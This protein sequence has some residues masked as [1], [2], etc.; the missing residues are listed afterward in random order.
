MKGFFERMKTECFY[1]H[2][3]EDLSLDELKIYLKNY[4]EWYNNDRVKNTLEGWSPV[5]YRLRL[6]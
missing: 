5:Q 1:N 6:F 2:S 3:L 4:I